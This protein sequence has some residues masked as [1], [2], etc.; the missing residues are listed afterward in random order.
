[1]P[2]NE[3]RKVDAHLIYIAYI[4]S[5]RNNMS[6]CQSRCCSSVVFYSESCTSCRGYFTGCMHSHHHTTPYQFPSI[7]IRITSQATWYRQYFLSVFFRPSNPHT[8]SLRLFSPSI[9]LGVRLSNSNGWNDWG[10]KST[11]KTDWIDCGKEMKN[12]TREMRGG[13]QWRPHTNIASTSLN[14]AEMD[15][16]SVCEVVEF[17]L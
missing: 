13:N 16:E 15:G 3:I 4:L 1:M 8:H 14:C 5:N 2:L 10:G 6:K 12:L 9:G 7:Y 11:E 17:V